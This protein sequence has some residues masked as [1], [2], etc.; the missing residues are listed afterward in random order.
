[1]LWPSIRTFGPSFIE[2]RKPEFSDYADGSETNSVSIPITHWPC[3]RST[4]NFWTKN[5]CRPIQLSPQTRTTAREPAYRS[6]DSRTVCVGAGQKLLRRC[7]RRFGKNASNH[8]PDR[9]DRQERK[10]EGL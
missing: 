3:C 1:M 2:C 10:C 9:E 7:R 4:R 6:I 5:G 8:R